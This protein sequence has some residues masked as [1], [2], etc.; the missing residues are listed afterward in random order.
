MKKWGQSFLVDRNIKDKIIKIAAIEKQDFV[1]EI[2]PGAGALT[3]DLAGLAGRLVAIEKDRGLAKILKEMLVPY[4]N[5]TIVEGDILEFD[6][7]KLDAKNIK[8]VGNLP[9]YITSPI[10]MHLLKNRKYIDS[11]LI[12]VQKE[13]AQR[14][15]ARPTTKDYSS[16]TLA[17]Q[18]YAAA[19][20]EI[21]ITKGVFFPRPDVDSSLVRIN[22]LKNS[23]VP[24]GN[25]ELLFKIIR[26]SFNQRRKTILN[27]LASRLDKTM[28]ENA[29]TAAGID[30]SRRGETLSLE[31][32]AKLAN[33]IDNI[34][35]L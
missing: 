28:L 14:I 27:A 2:G 8:V 3:E 18:F 4:K 26:L 25:E 21:A 19:S 5:T 15:I 29:F 23:A 20:I 13:V 10:I 24:V 33:T 9:Y 16:L 34:P 11:I 35:Y 30:P 31:E 1:L 6:I 22:I 12:T 7:G 17:I 32:F